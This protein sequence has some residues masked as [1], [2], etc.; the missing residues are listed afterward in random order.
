MR[1]WAGG[2][3]IVVGILSCGCSISRE[4]KR[5]S[6][7]YP[8]FRDMQLTEQEKS[9]SKIEGETGTHCDS[10]AKLVS[11]EYGEHRPILDG[12]G[13]AIGIPRRILL[14][15]KRVDNHQVSTE[16]VAQVSD[17]IADEGVNGVKLRV[18]QYA[19]LDEFRRLRDNE[20]LHAGWKYT[21][22]L[23]EWLGYTLFPGR[24]WGGDSYNPYTNTLS[25][26]SDV[27]SLGIVEAAYAKDV[28]N[29]DY[30]G[31]YASSQ[32]LPIVAMWHE[33]KA[34]NETLTYVA[35]RGTRHEQNETKK[36]LYARYGMELGGEIG[37]L[38]QANGLV[39][40]NVYQVIGAVGG[41]IYA[42]FDSQP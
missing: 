3:W 14:W 5:F 26:Y 6:I 25:I 20:R 30:P 41:H 16:T 19:P 39:I 1:K 33:T 17:Y 2:L 7:G 8:A 37:G 23:G 10:P 21:F 12:V 36:L 22:G 42:G 34:T 32:T 38:Q 27:A 31:L 11:I 13:W 28:Q 18:N 9:A 24:V 4:Q 15:D 40:G 35:L 29:Q